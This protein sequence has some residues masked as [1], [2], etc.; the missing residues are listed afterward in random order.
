MTRALTL[1]RVHFTNTLREISS[2]VSRR[3]AEAS[4]SDTAMTGL[5]YAKFRVGASELKDLGLEL[6]KRAGPASGAEPGAQGEYQSLVN[7]LHQSYAAARDR[8]L[9]PMIHKKL[10][11]LNG[12]PNNMKDLI[13][14]VRSTIGYVRGLCLDEYDL[15]HEWFDGE[16]GLYEFLESL[17]E[18]LYD[19][20]RPRTIKETQL[21]KLCE[22]CSLIQVRY[23]DETEDEMDSTE[24]VPRLQFSPLIRPALE[25]A[26]TRLVFLAVAVLRDDIERYRPKPIDLETAGRRTRPRVVG[27]GARPPALSGRKTATVDMPQSPGPQIPTAEGAIDIDPFDIGW[28]YEGGAPVT[29]WYPTLRKAI[30]LLS[31]IYR[32]V[33]V[34]ME[35]LGVFG[36]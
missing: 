26:Q 12:T 22:M 14:F 35:T 21:Q 32:L 17:C 27:A 2:D 11:E 19:Y 33:N 3:V 20:L 5:L 13:S 29:E 28:S 6:Q 36:Y 1:V 8:L 24:E 16:A 25:D 10:A 15:W 31:R 9:T 34:S 18:P 23:M 7:E 4:V 30:W